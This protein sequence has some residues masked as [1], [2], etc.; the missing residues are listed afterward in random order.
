MQMVYDGPISSS[1]C[2]EIDR[3]ELQRLKAYKL[4]TLDLYIWWALTLEFGTNKAELDVKKL[5]S[6]CERWS[7]HYGDFIDGANTVFKFSVQ[8]ALITIG[9]LSKKQGSGVRIA[10]HLS[11]DLS[12]N[13]SE[14][15]S[16]D[17]S[18]NP[19]NSEH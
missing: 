6:F 15:L 16:L 5:D 3:Q 12:G 7:F 13:N 4:I 2:I 18:G 1:S 14:Q 19:D 17:L 11:L 8:D 9:K 10:V